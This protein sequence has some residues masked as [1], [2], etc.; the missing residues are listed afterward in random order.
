MFGK[1]KYCTLN[2]LVIFRSFVC[3]KKNCFKSN[4]FLWSAS[5]GLQYC[6]TITVLVSTS[7]IL[8]PAARPVCISFFATK[9]ILRVIVIYELYYFKVSYESVQQ[10]FCDIHAS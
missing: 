8:F 7:V 2:L 5:E 1:K 10:F 3:E 6:T 4:L 9:G